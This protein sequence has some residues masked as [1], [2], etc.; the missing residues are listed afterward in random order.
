MNLPNKISFS[1]I[2]MVPVFMVFIMPF[3][4]WEILSGFNSF[5]SDWGIYIA[6]FIF[7]VASI[8]DS[9]DGYIARSRNMITDFGRFIDP[10]ADKL[11]VTAA[12]I[13]LV[14]QGNL[15]GW[16]AFIIIGRELIITG[17]RLLINV[18]GTGKGKVIPA[19][20]WGK[21]KTILQTVAITFLILEIKLQNVLTWWDSKTVTIGQIIM[22]AA[23]I[24]TIVSGYIYIKSNFHLLKDDM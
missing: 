12:V 24:M 18:S 19:N 21:L 1:R 11:L 22:F 7:V 6:A 23:I 13:A 20:V 8:T 3:P 14:D 9:I 15:N 5:I 4:Q 10:I 16:C 2:L 17:F